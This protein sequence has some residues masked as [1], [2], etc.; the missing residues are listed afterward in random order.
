MK[1]SAAQIVDAAIKST[2][3][4]KTTQGGAVTLV[5][6]GLTVSEWGVI[7][8]I[9]LGILGYATQLYYKRREMRLKE[10]YYAKHGVQ[11][12]HDLDDK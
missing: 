9:I 2:I 6:C 8:G 5:I 12:T 11:D 1:E 10:L 4:H 3:A 7:T